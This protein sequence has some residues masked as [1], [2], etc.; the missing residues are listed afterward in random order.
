MAMG[1]RKSEQAPLWIPTTE[2]PVSPGHPFYVRLNEVLA[3]AGFDRFVED[4]CRPFYAP[5]MG[6]PSLAPGRYFRLLLVG[7]F[8]GLDSERGIAWRA[9]D[10]LAVR[11][12]LGLGL[13]EA[14]PD[15]STIS[16][17]RRLIDLEAHQAVFTWVQERLVDTQLL[18]GK[19]LAVDATTLEANAA[20]RSI[21]RRDTG[22][23][24]QKFLTRLA[25]ASGLKT[26]TREALA[27]LDRRRKK[28]TANAEWVNP[29]DPD[30]QVT[31]MKDGRTHLAHKVEHAVDL[32]TG[33]LVAVT[34][35]GADVGDTT[36]LLATTLPAA[37]QLA[38]V[39]ASAPTALIGDRGYHSNDTLLTLRALGLRAYLTEPDR[40][41][42]CWTKEPEAQQPVYGNRRRVGG[43]RG[44]QL[45][46]RRG[47]YVERTFAHVYDTGG[48]RRI[49]LRGH[50]NILK[51]LIVH[52]G[53]FNLGL[54]M[55][56]VFG[57]GTP[58]GLQGRR[59]PYFARWALLY[60]LLAAL[61]TTLARSLGVSQPRSHGG[62]PA[63]SLAA[64]YSLQ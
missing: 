42:R 62:P 26:P 49:H 27:R 41:R 37:E 36:S 8:E 44:K 53:A 51:R 9:A 28:R 38:A 20:M 15:H 5:V 13:D 11:H 50:P 45:M 57:R 52:A 61:E 34:L 23:S 3:D 43:P 64:R 1:K 30:A 39:H 10:S 21:V 59:R 55:R 58:R 60:T 32:D 16:R 63:F 35:H 24:Y 19:T 54:L 2:L 46:R 14:A 31:Q 29:S 6:R 48:L 33:A 18:R 17:T 56:H 40:G 25:T 47:E 12:F 7:Y 4:Q 22:E